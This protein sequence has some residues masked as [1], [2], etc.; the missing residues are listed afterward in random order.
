METNVGESIVIVDD[1]KSFT[2][3]IGSLL[4]DRLDAPVHT[5]SRPAAALENFGSLRAGIVVTDYYMPGM[6]G[7]DFIRTVHALSPR[8]P[9]LLI[10]GHPLALE[11]HPAQGDLSN[12]KAVIPKPFRWQQLAEMIRL[13]WGGAHPPAYRITPNSL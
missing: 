11:D 6:N 10:T 1:E 12:L 4:A 7:L 13:H 5:F 2:E 3:L 9:C 8:T